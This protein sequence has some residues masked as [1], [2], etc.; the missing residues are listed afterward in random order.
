MDM[1]AHTRTLSDLLSLNKKYVVPRFQREYSWGRDEITALWKDIC[2]QLKLKAGKLQP[3]EYFV[4]CLVL[5][6][7]DNSKEQK[8]VDGQQRL[9]TL[10][11]LLRAL[12]T[13]LSAAG[14]DESAKS[15]YGKYIEGQD[16][17]GKT[18]FKLIN[19]SPKPYFQNAIQHFSQEDQ[20]PSSD[21]ERLLKL[22]YDEFIDQLWPTKLLSQHTSVA[23]KDK[24]TALRE[25]ILNHLKFIHVLV[26]D[27]DDA[28]TIFET[29]NARGINLSA[30]DLVKNWL[31]KHLPDE[32]PT[33]KAKSKWDGMKAVLASSADPI[34]KDT[35][36]RHF[37]LSNYGFVN[38]GRIYRSFKH[39]AEA[40]TIV[41][42]T[43]QDHLL[44][45]ARS[46]V[47]LVSP[48]AAD[49][50]HH[51]EREIFGSLSALNLFRVSA[52]RPLLLALVRARAD[53]KLSASQHVRIMRDLENFHFLY[54]AI[55]SG[56]S[57]GFDG[58]YSRAARD[59]RSA[60]G[61]NVM[62]VITELLA[63][64]KDKKPTI[65]VF[66]SG[67][68]ELWYSNEETKNKRIIQYIFNRHERYLRKTKELAIDQIS[69]EHIAPQSAAKSIKDV[70]GKIGNLLPLDADINS[71]AGSKILKLKLNA[72]KKSQLKIVD[73]FAKKYASVLTWDAAQIEK[74][75]DELAYISYEKIWVL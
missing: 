3:T 43:F 11:I 38:E 58:R 8:I 60:S 37:W 61:P 12:I 25:Q 15:I 26:A 34:D 18:F 4:G 29:L 14:E 55:T 30:I 28:Y 74:R 16:D 24:L 31:L 45:E 49:A 47:R 59:V 48:I 71:D 33:D 75:T 39:L 42:S 65:D 73:Q 6:G 62:G 22:A 17:D 54:T 67:F 2:D 46:Y 10:T 13:V 36:F 69:L 51:L 56:N 5:V 66:K 27:E 53:K 70:Y 1:Q 64:L 50:K 7:K 32:H 40:G 63:T 52:A 57:S 21:E 68:H 19:E 23:Y 44:E 9:T 20:K 72:Y 41:A 35:F